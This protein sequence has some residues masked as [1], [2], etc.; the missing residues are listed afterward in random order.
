MF[1]PP[2]HTSPNLAPFLLV[3]VLQPPLLHPLMDVAARWVRADVVHGTRGLRGKGV[4]VGVADP[5]SS[6]LADGW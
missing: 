6:G 1:R 3:I 4:W 5:R 2:K